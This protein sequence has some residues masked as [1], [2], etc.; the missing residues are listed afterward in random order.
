MRLRLLAFVIV[1]MLAGHQARAQLTLTDVQTII[2]Q[3]VARAVKI[4]P[5]SVIAVTDREG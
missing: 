1:P 5:N 2:N 3:A 4:S